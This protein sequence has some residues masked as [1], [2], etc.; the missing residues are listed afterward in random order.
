MHHSQKPVKALYMQVSA[1]CCA[2]MAC[3]LAVIDSHSNLL[4]RGMFCHNRTEARGCACCIDGSTLRKPVSSK[5]QKQLSITATQQ[6]Q[7]SRS[8]SNCRLTDLANSSVRRAKPLNFSFSNFSATFSGGDRYH[9]H[10]VQGL[11]D[12]PVGG[13]SLL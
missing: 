11:G 13:I 10:V 5:C 3:R 1:I 9:R 4:G 2:C 8:V 7:N 6:K 12:L